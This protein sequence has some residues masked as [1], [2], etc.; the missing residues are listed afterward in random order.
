MFKH[1]YSA[2][3]RCL[4]DLAGAQ[5]RELVLTVLRHLPE[6]IAFR[7]ER[8]KKEE[9][10]IIKFSR[11]KQLQF[12]KEIITKDMETSSEVYEN[13]FEKFEKS[14]KAVPR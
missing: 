9:Q 2:S 6:V 3:S 14:H 4:G 13:Y 7:V 10:Y 1:L 8:E 5:Y 11:E 12:C